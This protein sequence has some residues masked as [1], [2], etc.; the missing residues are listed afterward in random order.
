MQDAVFVSRS[1]GMNQQTKNGRSLMSVSLAQKQTRGVQEEHVLSLTGF[2]GEGYLVGWSF[3][4]HIVLVATVRA[5]QLV[6]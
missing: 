4:D 5:P 6:T 2:L 1:H 3:Q